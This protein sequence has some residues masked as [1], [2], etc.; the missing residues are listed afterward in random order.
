VS[1]SKKTQIDCLLIGHNEMNFSD[2]ERDIR[3]MGTHSGAYRDLNLN[4]ILYDNQPYTASEIFNLFYCSNNHGKDTGKPVRVTEVF[5]AAISYLGTY[6]SRRGFVFDYVNAFQVEKEALKQ[7]LTQE[8]I[9]TIAIITTLY[10]SPLPIIE[11]IDFIKQNNRTAK[12][13]IGGPFVSTRFQVL[14]K[15]ALKFLLESTLDV[16][17]YVNSSQGE[18]T[19]T[20]ILHALKNNLPLDQVNN[21][22]YK[23]GNGYQ[24]TPILR[25]DNRLSEN[26]VDWSLFSQR[27]GEYVNARTAISCPFS[28][29]FCGFPQH[30]GNYQTAPVEEIEKEL[31]MIEQ[32]G[33]VK[34]V[35]FIDDT[36]NVPRDRFK[37]ILK[38]MIANKYTFNWHSHYR[39]QFADK[40]TVELMKESGCEG[41]F[42]GI[43][44]G[45]NQ[46]LQNMKKAV[47]VEKYFEGVS[48]LKKCGILT[49]G[50]FIIGFPGETAGTMADT[51]RFIKESGIDFYRAQLWYCEPITPIWKEREQYQLTGE[52]FEWSHSTMDSPTACALIEDMFHTI[53]HPTW[54]P[55]YNFE[56][57][58]LFQLLHRGMP[59]EK[60][61]AFLNAFN[62]GV[63]EKLTNPSSQE[64]SFEVINR[65]KDSCP[66]T[67]VFKTGAVTGKEMS[68]RY[69]ADFDF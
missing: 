27:P 43:E 5:S 49:Y 30:A 45:N 52:S 59:M 64:V 38:M 58:G 60:V 19:L 40:E 13:V 39:C 33:T 55:Q 37:K 4:F 17:I 28:C 57:A 54:V 24:G 61:K 35:H 67:P 62:D 34:S 7:K 3:K 46:V 41:V 21:I 32:I 9:L 44:S 25:E 69:Q 53:D 31:N 6:L 50:S 56:F 68:S 66:G 10:V 18:L 23:T 63:K 36:F 8:N 1:T 16:D 2:Y 20:R 29:S 11:I 26:M 14:N 47:S 65:I 15:E 48:L 51:L 42:L 22:Y 12:I